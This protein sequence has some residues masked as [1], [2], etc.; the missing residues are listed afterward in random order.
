MRCIA[1]VG[2]IFLLQAARPAWAQDCL[3]CH[4]LSTGLTNLAGKDI[5][6]NPAHLKRSVHGDLA[7]VDCHAGAAQ[8]PHTARQ[9]AASCSRC[10]S[11]VPGVLAG[12]VHAALGD[13][14]DAQTCV[15]CHGAHDV[16]DPST[17]G[18]RLCATCHST[19][20]KRYDASIHGRARSRGISDAPTCQNCHGPAHQ[21]LT[22]TDAKSPVSKTNL[23]NTCGTC[24]SNPKLAAKY[25]FSVVLPVAAYEAGVHGRAVAQGNLNAASCADCHGA[26]DILPSSDPHSR[27]WK[28]TVPA[29]CGQCHAAVF[30]V[31]K[32][33]IHGTALAAGVLGAATCTD[34]HGEHRILAPANPESSVFKANVSQ[35]TCSRCHGDT[36]LMA[37]F[38]IPLNRV[39][40]YEDSFHGLAAREGRQTVAD[41]ASCHGVH[42]IYRANDPRSTVNKANLAR[43]CGQ[44]HSDAGRLFAIG[45]VHALPAS[46]EA[47]HILDF[48]NL[49]YALAIPGILGLMLFHNGLDW[50]KKAQR[51]LAQQRGRGQLR[52][53][54][55]ERT[56]HFVLLT[57]FVVL[58]ITGFALKYPGAFWAAPI[59]RWEGSFP[60]RGWLH[61]MAGV[62][63]IGASVY[64]VVYLIKSRDGW[65]WFKDMWPRHRDL[66]D[67]VETVGYNLG[68]R[69]V[70]P[71]YA[72]FNYIEKAEYWALVWGVAV[73]AITGV[74]LWAHNWVLE[75]LPQPTSILDILTAIHFFEAILATLAI[76]IW[77]FYAVIFDP[78]E[79]PMKWTFLTGRNPEH[80]VREPSPPP[81]D[82]ET[83]PAA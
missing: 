75:F 28:Q 71:H 61:R 30:N 23:P 80:D 33:S 62:I 60:L 21:V 73:M 56:Q 74:L 69:P 67:A 54:L 46:T 14:N 55:N 77:H 4:G 76:L 83:D 12:S 36:Q 41:C 82:T 57:S 43:T 70:P 34:C 38:N 11:D 20:V 40:T 5:T 6:V 44:C 16:K 66:R 51:T 8:V 7:C 48:V 50:W 45:P 9:A 31:Y 81:P 3:A 39:P 58:V 27:I 18:V 68:Y 37:S 47:A 2:L 64:H 22:A 13:P 19:E 49:F 15:A 52:M 17:L 24:H 78:T 65:R 26:H 32:G 72:R 1:T 59:V 42:N 79:Y 25:L 35:T 63:L 53:S 10:H 29:T